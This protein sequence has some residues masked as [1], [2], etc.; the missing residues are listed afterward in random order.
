M[1]ID[2]VLPAQIISGSRSVLHLLG[3]NLRCGALI[4]RFPDGTVQ[5][6]QGSDPGPEAE[7]R[8]VRSRFARRVLLGGDTGFAEAYMDGDCDSPNLLAVV[9][10]A[11]AN[12]AAWE[13]TLQGTTAFRVASR[14]IHLVRPNSRRQARRNIAQHYDL[15]NS[16]YEQWLDPGLTYSGGIYAQ[17]D[18]SLADAQR[19][20]FR[21]IAE[22][23]GLTPDQRVLEIGCGW[24]G[25][26]EFAAREIGCNVTAITISEQQY[27]YAKARMARHG[28]ADLV[29]VR[30]LD[31]RDLHGQFDRIVSIEMFEA[32]GE[33]YWPVFFE[34]VHDVLTPGGRAALQVITM[35]DTAWESYRRQA[36]FIQR[37]VF[38]G[39]MLP[40]P[41]A[42]YRGAAQAGLPV[43]ACNTYGLDYACTLADWHRRF[44]QAWPAISRLGFDE[45]FRRLWKYYLAYCEGGFRAG[46]IDVMQVALERG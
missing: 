18:A 16:F 36:D 35:E 34:K 8:I 32:V 1:Q 25:F 41:D 19:E 37:Y 26:A 22:L 44:D 45:R 6:Y 29:D 4:L 30:L 23:A 46:R 2:T 5:R 28:L 24:G 7:L 17:P 39:G 38:P 3:Q 31:Y 27:A 21:R 33:R 43:A 40:S 12:W 15:G 11:L 20:K 13:R 42:F 10:L 14:L 9:E